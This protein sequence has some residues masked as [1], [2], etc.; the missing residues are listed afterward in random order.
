[1]YISGLN[2]NGKT[3]LVEAIYLLSGSR[4]FRTNTSSELLKW[5]EKECSIFGTVTTAN[6]TEELGLVFTPGERRALSNGKELESMTDL[7]GRL[8]VIAFSPADLSLVK[9]S[10]AGR[11]RFLDRH[12]VDLNPPF[13]KVLMSYQRALASKSAV[14]KQPG[15]TYA[16][17][18]P[19]NELLAQSCGKIVDNRAKFLESLS[20]KSSGFHR[21]Y[22]PSDGELKITLESDFYQDGRVLSDEDILARFENAAPREMAM[23]SATLGAQRD[24]V[25][26]TLGGMDA[27]AFASQGQTRSVVLSMKLGVIEMIESATGESPVVILDDVDSELDRAR[28]E[29][30]FT[31][32]LNKPRQVIVTG[33]EGPS[34]QLIHSPDLRM[35]TVSQGVVTPQ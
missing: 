11:R 10:P 27:R 12:M 30:L 33:T 28:S 22:A 17:V 31:A 3:N 35:V 32:L 2:G 13:I 7:I 8:R 34:P 14:L 1:M 19:W 16:H 18:K 4:S 26:V 6:G 21:L 23:R 20:D 25:S 29:R 24:D 9:G 5:G 15:C